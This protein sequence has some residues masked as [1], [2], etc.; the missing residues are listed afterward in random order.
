MNELNLRGKRDIDRYLVLEFINGFCKGFCHIDTKECKKFC[1]IKN[2]DVENC[3][4][5]KIKDILVQREEED[6][7]DIRIST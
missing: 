2:L 5:F 4:S 1:R 3:G 6:E 7:R